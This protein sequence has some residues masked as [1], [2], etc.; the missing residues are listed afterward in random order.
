M[1]ELIRKGILSKVTQGGSLKSTIFHGALAAKSWTK[2]VPIVG[3]VVGAVTDKAVFNQVKAATG[4][5]LKYA[6]NGGRVERKNPLESKRKTKFT[7]LI[8]FPFCSSFLSLPSARPSLPLA[9]ARY[10]LLTT[11]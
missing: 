10:S 3:S 7:D 9:A 4:G 2:R 11:T 1:W 6:V 8:F 5:N